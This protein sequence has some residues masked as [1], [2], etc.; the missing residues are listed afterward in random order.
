MDQANCAG[1]CYDSGENSTSTSSFTFGFGNSMWFRAYSGT[2][3]NIFQ[4]HPNIGCEFWR[5]SIA[6]Q[7]W[8]LLDSRTI[9]KSTACIY[10]VRSDDNVS[11]W[12]PTVRYDGDDSYLFLFRANT[13][14]GE[15]SRCNDRVVMYN[16]GNDNS[17]NTTVKGKLLYGKPNNGVVYHTTDNRSGGTELAPFTTIGMRGTLITGAHVGHMISVRSAMSKT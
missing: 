1:V 15:R 8:V 12:S 17:W 7:S 10:Q 5:F 11:G 13:T 3:S 2:A 9:G 16:I 6:S 4:K 14:V